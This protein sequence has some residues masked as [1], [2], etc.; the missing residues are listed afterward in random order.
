MTPPTDPEQSVDYNNLTHDKTIIIATAYGADAKT[1]RKK[2]ISVSEFV[3][4]LSVTKRTDETLD[5]FLKMPKDQQDEIKSSNGAFVGAMLKGNRRRKVDVANRSLLTMDLDYA[6]PVTFGIIKKELKTMCYTVY[7][8]H[9]NA[10]AHPRL[11]LIVY[12]DRAMTVEEYQAAVRKVSERVGM[13]YFDVSGFQPNRLYYLPTTSSD[14][15]YI[16]HHNDA[17]FVSV[18]RVLASYGPDDAWKNTTLLP[19]GDREV[20]NFDRLLKKQADPLTKKGI[21]GAFCRTVSIQ[22]ALETHLKDVYRK[23]SGDRYTYIDG[24]TFGGMVVYDDKFAYS[25]HASDPCSNQCLNAF[26]LIRT[27]LFVHLDE[28]V[29]DGV[30]GT[31]L[32]SYREMVEWSRGLEGVKLELIKSKLDIDASAF[33]DFDMD[34]REKEDWETKLQITETGLVKPTFL[35]AVTILRNDPKINGLMRKNLF[36]ENME[37]MAGDDWANDDSHQVREYVGWRYVVDFPEKKIEDAID[38]NANKNRYHPVRDYL[39]GREWDGVERIDTIFIDYFGCVDN[40]YVREAARCWFVA[41]VSRVFEPGFKFDTALVISGAQGI[42]KTSFVR[43]LGLVKWYGELSSFDPKI[44]IEEILGK[45]I[46][47]ISEMGATNKQALEQQKSFLSACSTRVRLA[48]ERRAVDYKRQC[49][50]IGSTNE[51]EYL[52]DSTGNR[53]WWPLEAKVESVDIDK[54]RKDVGQIW[55]EAYGL[56]AQGCSVFLGKDAL[57]IALMEQDDKR[58]ADPWEGIVTEWLEEKAY[59]DRYESKAQFDSGDL[60]K[61]DR[62]CIMEVWDDCL[63]MQ[64]QPKRME[65]MRIGRIITNN[66]NWEKSV[67]N[68]RFGKRYGLQKAWRNDIPF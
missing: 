3:K 44:G 62:V 17:P 36:S 27:H 8:T 41:A 56:W 66:P 42:G 25:H 24:S 39:Q 19:R 20:T 33:D 35:N 34:D 43:E 7:S 52:K 32:P 65:R 31:K 5:E 67:S 68:M 55:A 29:G 16:F 23:E 57:E 58:E 38:N 53:R 37:N 21:V 9:K 11:R 28:K 54:L 2:S 4:T 64:R 47:E 26:D 14:S 1:W 22:E 12:P 15:D 46:V 60:E 50:F 49:V 6:K 61:R 51:V 30:S 13:E 45:W 10:S 59:S 40:A 48:Y 18:D 63:N